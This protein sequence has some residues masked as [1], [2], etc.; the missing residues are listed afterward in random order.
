MLS[1]RPPPTQGGASGTFAVGGDGEGLVRVLLLL[2]TALV[3]RAFLL[4]LLAPLKFLC[5]GLGFAAALRGRIFL[6]LVRLVVEDG[7]NCLLAGSEVAGG[8]E[9]FVGAGGT[10]LRKLMHQVPARRT[11]EEGIDDLDISDAGE[12]GALLG[13][14]SHVVVQGFVGLLSTP[15]EIPGVP[16]RTYVPWKLP[17]KI[18]T[19]STQS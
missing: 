1:N 13:E 14:A 19:R 12:F 8:I 17:T 4:S 5:G 10:A 9:Q 16:G 15:S 6:A 2:L 3:L 11:L 18:L 7:T